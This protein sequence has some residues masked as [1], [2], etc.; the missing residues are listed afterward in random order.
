MTSSNPGVEIG[1]ISQ[2]SD[3][4]GK[5]LHKE[6]ACHI[7][8]PESTPRSPIKHKS[9]VLEKTQLLS[10]NRGTITIVSLGKK[11]FRVENFTLKITK[12][13]FFQKCQN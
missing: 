9:G 11:E 2:K 12:L 6:G 13:F 1:R 8:G 7:T 10:G 5:M 4:Q 3:I